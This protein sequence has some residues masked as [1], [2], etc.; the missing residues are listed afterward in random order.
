MVEQIL[1]TV[2]QL[3]SMTDAQV[4][5]LNRLL[6]SGSLTSDQHAAIYRLTDA[7]VEGRITLS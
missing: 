6:S 5:H 4:Q 2:W 3:G 1:T 7:L